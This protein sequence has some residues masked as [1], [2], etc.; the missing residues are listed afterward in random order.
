MYITMIAAINAL[1]YCQRFYGLP[2]HQFFCKSFVFGLRDIIFHTYIYA[3]LLH[4]KVTHH[5]MYSVSVGLYWDQVNSIPY[6]C[7]KSNFFC[8]CIF[9]MFSQC[10][11]FSDYQIWGLFNRH[12]PFECP[13]IMPTLEDNN[14]WIDIVAQVCSSFTLVLTMN[15]IF[16]I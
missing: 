13:E 15:I 4:L 6:T 5:M 2:L 9:V 3:L 7:M 16:V 12:L 8:T 1:Y 14:K 10:S 11:Y